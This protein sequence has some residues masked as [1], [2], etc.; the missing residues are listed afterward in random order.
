MQGLDFTRSDQADAARFNHILWTGLKGEDVPYPTT[1]SGLD[2]RKNR[3]RL[4][5]AAI[6]DQMRKKQQAAQAS[7]SPD[8][9]KNQD[10]NVGAQN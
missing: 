3:R 7:G 6:E 9:I 1:R 10:S 5:A 4:L 8:A 2:L